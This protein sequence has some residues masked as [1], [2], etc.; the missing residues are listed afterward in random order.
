MV[1]TDLQPLAAP[2]LAHWRLGRD[3]GGCA[4]LVL[5]RA[6]AKVNTLSAAVLGELGPALDAVAAER[7][8]GLILCSAK[9]GGFAAGAD[10]RE[11]AAARTVD[12]TAAEVEAVHALFAR[13]A[14]LGVPT[15]ARVHGHCLGGGLE[16]ALACARIVAADDAATRFGLPEVMLGIHPGFGGTVRTPARIGALPAL[17]LMLSGRSL[18]AR[19]ARALG[20]VDVVVPRRHLDV[21]ARSCVVEA[22]PRARPP[23]ASRLASPLLASVPLRPLVARA[24]ARAV[25]KRAAPE[26]YPAPHRLLALWRSHGGRGAAAFHA[27]AR[28]V[29]ELVASPAS[30]ALV[31]LF[32]EQ[33]R[34]KDAGRGQDWQPHRVHVIG[35]GTMGGDIAAWCALRGLEVT[36]TDRS[37]AFVA[38]AVTRAGKLFER[39]LS[40]RY[41]RARA[42]DRLVADFAGDGVV[43]A[44]VVIEAIVEDL[45]AKRELFHEVERHARPGALLATNT[46]SIPLAAIA[47]DLAAPERLVGIHFFNPVAQMQ[48]VEVVGDR[49][50]A[51]AATARACA[52]AVAID[53]LPLPT[54][55]T[56]GFLVNRVLSPYLQ[57]AMLLVQEGCSVAAV[58]AVA[59]AFGMPMGPLTLADTVGLDV[60]LQVG[61]ILAAAFGG[62]VPAPLVGAVEAGRLGRKSGAGFYDYG[63]RRPRPLTPGAAIADR[64]LVRDRLLLRLL[65]EAVACLREGVVADAAALDVAMVFGTGFAP[66]TGGPLAYAR[67]RGVAGLRATLAGLASRYG[68]RFAPDAGWETLA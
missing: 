28:S 3:G 68:P 62:E 55:S 12:D 33:E 60:C 13:L 65:N 67:T 9:A 53:R 22:R 37:P 11:F 17:E 66:F 31:G 25:A 8:R 35:A 47:A 21:A 32:L 15:V 30:R 4:W 10:V 20:L 1:P 54:A 16:L 27:E 59:T 64:E 38:R 14:A 42:R 61:R 26:H 2:A 44:D 23:L 57:E 50:T 46:S 58:D 52:F 45:A 19:R 41:E 43:R 40:D 6:E 7:P 49:H 18:S 56:P 36:L 63:G 48:L 5:D 29:A 24:L 51:A 39:R 34:L